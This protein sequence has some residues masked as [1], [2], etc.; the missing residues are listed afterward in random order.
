MPSKGS[1]G[2]PKSS[3]VKSQSPES[4]LTKK[5]N[6]NS[7]DY[8]GETHVYIIRNVEEGTV[9]KVGESMQGFNRYGLSKRA[10]AQARKLETQTGIRYET[11][12][13]RIFKGKRDARDFETKFI[14]TS[15]K[16]YGQDK[17]PG[18]K[19]LH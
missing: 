11:V 3:K 18:N 6:S 14:K 8:M 9:Y 5:I 7:N 2:K 16:L 17:L 15:R 13:R 19:G 12:I 1:S 4:S 10:A